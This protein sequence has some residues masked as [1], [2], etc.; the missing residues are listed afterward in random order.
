[1][2]V[3]NIVIFSLI[4][5]YMLL[6]SVLFKYRPKNNEFLRRENTNSVIG[7]AIL[8]IIFHHIIQQIVNPGILL[9]FRGVGYLFVSVFFFLSGYGL[10][11]SCINNKFN[12]KGFFSRRLSKVYIPFV[13]VNFINLL[14]N[15]YILNKNYTVTEFLFKLTG[16]QL[17]S[18]AMWYIKSIIFWYIIFYL[19]VRKSRLSKIGI[20]M[21]L[22][23]LIYFVV[24]CTMGL[25]KNWYDTSFIF[26]IGVI[27]GLNQDKIEEIIIE[28]YNLILICSLIIFIISFAA[29]FGK[30]D[31]NSIIIRSIASVTFTI[32]GIMILMKIDLS[33]NKVSLFLGSISFE[34]FLIHDRMLSILNI[35]GH[36]TS[37]NLIIYFLIIILL[38]LTLNKISKLI[39]IRDLKVV[40]NE[41]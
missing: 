40:S 15:I 21:M 20:T 7:I 5:L 23:A 16:I 30:E 26:P 29:N 18:S 41:K 38:S 3:D 11:K 35:G 4:S 25:S 27:V 12:L 22:V 34:L 36:V 8:C 17:M 24:C 31:I 13:I 32:A 39:N 19:V 28:K 6:T 10:I 2:I 33:E 1:M 37:I 9:P 14:I